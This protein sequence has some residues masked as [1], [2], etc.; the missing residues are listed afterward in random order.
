MFSKLC[1][2]ISCND[3]CCSVLSTQKPRHAQRVRPVHSN[4]SVYDHYGAAD[5]RDSFEFTSSILRRGTTGSAHA[6][7]SIPTARR[8]QSSNSS[9][10]AW[11]QSKS[12]SAALSS[13]SDSPVINCR[14]TFQKARVRCCIGVTSA[15]GACRRRCFAR[16]QAK[17]RYTHTLALQASN[18]ASSEEAYLGLDFGTSGARAVCIT[19]TG[20]CHVT[21]F[22]ALIEP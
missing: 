1:T 14:N 5:C 8:L 19:G 22:A 4:A 13:H 15:N 16:L 7:L 21:E 10:I 2:K 11:M 6:G 20:I 12:W 3:L 18:L 17:D 9:S